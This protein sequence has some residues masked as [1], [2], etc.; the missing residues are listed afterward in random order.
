MAV[1]AARPAHHHRQP[2]G[3][4]W[5]ISTEAVVRAPSDGYTLLQVGTS[6]AV[7]T[8]LYKLD[9]DLV[10]DIAPVA[11]IARALVTSFGENS[12]KFTRTWNGSGQ[13]ASR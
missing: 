5:H 2:A 7:N 12:K 10:R 11:G 13:S 9:F 8:T 4:R 6:H 3:R 1:G